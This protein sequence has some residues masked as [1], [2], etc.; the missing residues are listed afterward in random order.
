MKRLLL[1]ILLLPA[2]AWGQN[3]AIRLLVAAPPGGGTDVIFRILA[4]EA[5]PLLGDPIVIQNSPA[6]GGIVAIEQ[7]LNG[8][9][10]GKLLVGAS[11]GIIT[12]TPH[13][14]GTPYS[15]DDFVPLFGISSAPYVV[16]AYSNF[17]AKTPADF[18]SVLKSNPDKYTIG[19]DGQTGWL[20]TQRIFKA[21][22]ISV[23]NISYKGASEIF[24]SFMGQHIDLYSG[25]ALAVKSAV[26]SGKAKCF[27]LT[28]AEKSP[29]YPEAAG[30]K[31]LGLEKEETPLWRVLLA[32]K[33]TPPEVMDRLA[34]AMEKAAQSAAI[35]KFHEDGGELLVT[36]RGQD[37][38]K[39]LRNE[40][41]AMGAVTK[42]LGI[43]NP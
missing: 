36:Y 17:P 35:K 16:C 21:L 31:E 1:L 34:E 23:R 20:A 42:S 43:K 40:Y 6:A 32:P 2:L 29:I 3:Q 19:T 39:K 13:L 11:N 27:L 30:L 7:M 26:D 22:G 10:D 25:S 18:V 38:Y 33:G 41:E 9:P 15:F 28:T 12:G 24:A 5:A 4:K 37:L 8:N 14:L